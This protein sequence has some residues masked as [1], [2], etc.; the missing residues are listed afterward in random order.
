MATKII[1]L[2]RA[3][4][5]IGLTVAMLAGCGQGQTV[6]TTGTLPHGAMATTQGR[7]HK[8]S[9]SSG[10]I[11]YVT[12]AQGLVL[13]SYPHWQILATVP[14]TNNGQPCSDP[15]NG[16]VYVVQPYIGQIAVY[17]HGGT[18]PINT[19]SAPA[20]YDEYYSCSVDPTNGDLAA[21]LYDSSTTKGAIAIYPNGQGSPRI[22]KTPKLDRFYYGDYDGA[23]NLYEW[24]EGNNKFRLVKLSAKKKQFSFI[25]YHENI[26][27]ENFH[28]DGQYFA[29]LT[30]N[31]P[32]Q[33]SSL[34][35]TQIVGSTATLVNT[36][37]LYHTAKIP[38]F[39]LVSGSLIG[40]FGR[41]KRDNNQALAS[42]PYPSGG[43]QTKS[44]YGVAKGKGN[45]LYGVTLSVAP[46]L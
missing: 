6:G 46:P 25:T 33:G 1:G 5:G 18:T 16:T 24:A 43:N 41:I 36:S 32:S 10:D 7:A 2:T 29:S 45:Q 22:Y 11:L 35:Q 17:A 26:V 8:A 28:W 15:N 44:F 31:S 27:I 20:P 9:G 3:A 38:N 23:G 40:F 21:L 13:V 39:C 4:L 34:Y 14:G 19:L 42:W 12:T 30:Y 37:I